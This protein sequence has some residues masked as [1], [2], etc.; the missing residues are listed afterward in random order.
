M[1]NT[2]HMDP[3]YFPE[4]EKFDP[5][6]FSDENKHNIKP[7]TFMPF[8]MG[9]RNCIGS[10]FALLEL[11][12]LLYSIVLNFKILKG[13]KTSDPIKLE[14]ADFNIRAVGGTFVRLQERK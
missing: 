3:E 2:I 8:G 1:V 11:K 6:R 14:A 10:R 7:F 5:D 9:P 13:P 12:V 4:P